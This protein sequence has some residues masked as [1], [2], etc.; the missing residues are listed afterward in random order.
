MDPSE[1]LVQDLAPLVGEQK[2]RRMVA[3]LLASVS[4]AASEAAEKPVRKMLIQATIGS[5]IIGAVTLVGFRLL[6]K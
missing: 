2:A 4:E 5:A 3:N 1:E 6:R